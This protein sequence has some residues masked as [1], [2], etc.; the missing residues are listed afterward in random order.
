MKKILLLLIMIIS[1]RGF[2]QSGLSLT[3]LTFPGTVGMYDKYEIGFDLS[4]V[5]TNPYD[6][7]IVDISVTFTGPSG[8]K[9]VNAFWYVAFDPRCT[10]CPDPTMTACEQHVGASDPGYL[11]RSAVNKYPWRVRLA[12]DASGTWTF[13]INVNIG[14][15]IFTFIN[16]SYQFYV[17]QSSNKGFVQIDGNRRN[18]SFRDGS[19]FYPVGLNGWAPGCNDVYNRLPYNW[20]MNEIDN[21]SA[22]GGNFLRIFATSPR[23]G[24]EWFNATDVGDGLVNFETRQNRAKDLDDVMDEAKAKGVYIQLCLESYEHF[25][26]SDCE[27]DP[28]GETW[29]WDRNPYKSLISSSSPGA[30]FT[31]P[32]CIA[33]YKKKLRYIVA[34]WSYATSL[35]SYEFFNEVDKIDH[36]WSGTSAADEITWH[37]TMINYCKPLDN[38][39]HLYTTSFASIVSGTAGGGFDNL[40]TIDYIQDHFYSA[41]Y[42]MD[43]KTNYLTNRS[44]QLF[45]KKPYIIGE[46]GPGYKT[47]S[48]VDCWLWAGSPTSSPLYADNIFHNY[49]WSSILSGGSGTALVWDNDNIFSCLNVGGW[50]GQA[51]Y[52]LPVNQFLAGEDLHLNKYKTLS[53]ACVSMAGA[54]DHIP[55]GV[56]P[57]GTDLT[58]DASTAFVNSG[59]TTSN[60]KRLE[61]FV[62]QSPDKMLGWVHNKEN[63]WYNLPHQ[64]GAGP[65]LADIGTGPNPITPLV[66]E[67]MTIGGVECDGY[68]KIEYY[69]VYPQININGTGPVDGGIINSLTG[70]AFARCGQLTFTLPTLSA[71]TSPST[72]YHAPDYGFKITKIEDGWSHIV[73]DYNPVNNVSSS[74][75]GVNGIGTQVGYRGNDG[76]L[77]IEYRSLGG[78]VWT[79]YEPADMSTFVPAQV[80]NGGAVN[81]GRASGHISYHGLDDKLQGYY[82]DISSGNWLHTWYVSTPWANVGGDIVTNDD[83]SQITYKGQDNELHVYYW[84]ISSASWQQNVHWANPSESVIGHIAISGGGGLIAYHGQ[85][86]RLQIYY[87]D[88]ASAS[89]VHTWFTDWSSTSQ[90]VTGSIAMSQDGT[91]IFYGGQDGLLHEYYFDGAT[92]SWQH[93]LV[94]L[95]SS[96]TVPVTGNIAVDDAGAQVYYRGGDGQIQV[97]YNTS[98]ISG[99]PTFVWDWLLCNSALDNSF[100]C[101]NN[102]AIASSSGALFYRGTDNELQAYPYNLGCTPNKF[103]NQQGHKES[104]ST[105]SDQKTDAYFADRLSSDLVYPN[106]FDNFLNVKLG[107][108]DTKVKVVD[109]YGKI[110]MEADVS[111]SEWVI[112]TSNYLAGIYILQITDK[113]SSSKFYKIVKQ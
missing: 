60:D 82:Y 46:C 41:D 14:G 89:W 104:H 111:G 29:G 54:K 99:A 58:P 5:F 100:E 76:R 36:F 66:R 69:S 67:T 87:W 101:I 30:F 103:K 1:H 33:A 112:Q 20:T 11:N 61:V 23:F 53:N 105:N 84:D 32:A 57:P 43:H 79:N 68:Y 80:A 50:G 21:L 47:A 92:A 98:G 38:N 65:C 42:D 52:F 17:N 4:S 16:P 12:P 37:N 28:D 102:G 108:T 113:N 35:M 86:N 83:G 2:G 91:K 94:R 15:T 24:I 72:D 107:T 27:A 90:N 8:S 70:T 26:T 45:P 49:V 59:I 62:L 93:C 81:R 51:A 63:Y 7:D 96:A 106:P 77:N 75:L 64:T 71:I 95:T 34:R 31:D 55:G 9:Q 110:M 10:S 88:I 78:T 19:I 3:A 22:N 44:N 109:I 18:Y 25:C 40:A 48:G 56:W 39:N 97:V 13:Q 74:S 85:D 6:P 73:V